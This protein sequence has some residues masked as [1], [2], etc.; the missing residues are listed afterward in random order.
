MQAVTSDVCSQLSQI[1]ASAAFSGDVPAA[2]RLVAASFLQGGQCAKAFADG[3]AANAAQLGCPKLTAVLV[4]AHRLAMAAGATVGRR[5]GGARSLALPL[6]CQPNLPASLPPSPS[7]LPTGAADAFVATLAANPA[8]L[9]ALR[10]C[11]SP[12]Q[13]LY[14]AAMP[15]PATPAAQVRWLT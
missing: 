4:E 11:L 1:V 10:A 9:D 12:A 8:L 7:H 15:A 13:T 5:L 3:L 6:P 2:A 14:G